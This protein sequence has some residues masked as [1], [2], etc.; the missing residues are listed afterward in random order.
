MKHEIEVQINE[1][2]LYAQVVNYAD[3]AVIEER[4][5]CVWNSESDTWEPGLVPTCTM[6]LLEYKMELKLERYL[7]SMGLTLAKGA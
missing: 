1:Y 7:D 3:S 5:Y 6:I 2:A 4:S